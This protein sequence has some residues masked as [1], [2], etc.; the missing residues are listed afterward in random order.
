[1]VRS[2]ADR[3]F[4]PSRVRGAGGVAFVVVVP[5]G[6]QAEAVRPALP[7]LDLEALPVA[8]CLRPLRRD[9]DLRTRLNKI[10]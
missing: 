3:T 7:V 5:R 8:L 4:Q 6:V 1:M 10:E 9:A 2:L